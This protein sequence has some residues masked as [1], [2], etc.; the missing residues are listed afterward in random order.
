MP[1]V[2]QVNLVRNASN[3]TLLVQGRINKTFI[4]RVSHRQFLRLSQDSNHENVAEEFLIKALKFP[5]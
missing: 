1:L 5:R 4:I 3:L 2:N